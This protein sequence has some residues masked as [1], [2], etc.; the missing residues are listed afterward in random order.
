MADELLDFFK[1][2]PTYFLST[3]DEDGNPQV[4]PFATFAKLDGAYYIQ[5]GRT[6]SVA[7]QIAAHPRVA[8]CGCSQ[9]GSQ[10]VRLEADA[11]DTHDA[12]LEQR[13]LDEY[14]ELGSMYKAGDGNTAAI[15][16]D[17]V[18][19]TLYSFTDAPR[20]LA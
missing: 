4:R 1:T 12:S 3:V 10:W 6:K 11:V 5:T 16:L 18:S 14:P 8:I 19:A 17:N 2:N 13:I 7:K 20:T 9:D 15:R